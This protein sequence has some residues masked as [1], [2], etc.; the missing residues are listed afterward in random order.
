MPVVVQHP[1]RDAEELKDSEWSEELG[2]VEFGEGGLAY[3]EEVLVEAG[4]GCCG[5]L[6]V[7]L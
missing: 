2:L 5:L 1:E 6:L 3:V 4:P 7:E